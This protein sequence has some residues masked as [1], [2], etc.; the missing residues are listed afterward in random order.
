MPTWY[1]DLYDEF[2]G[3]GKSA[4][5]FIGERFYNAGQSMD[6][7]GSWLGLSREDKNKIEYAVA[8]I[9]VLGDT[10]RARDNFNA[11]EDYMRITGTSWADIPYPSR[12][13]GAGSI[14]RAA[15]SLGGFVSKNIKDLYG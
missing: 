13:F 11:M 12:V 1:E 4:V 14:G 15:S 3:N 7:I 9:P 6:R 2:T 8:G 5:D 10:L